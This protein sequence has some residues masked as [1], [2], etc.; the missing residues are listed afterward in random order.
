MSDAQDLLP[1]QCT[2]S[3]A[4]ARICCLPWS[5]N[6]TIRSRLIRTDSVFIVPS[7]VAGA[8]SGVVF[9]GRSRQVQDITAEATR[10]VGWNR[11]GTVDVR[12]HPSVLIGFSVSTGS[13]LRMSEIKRNKLVSAIQLFT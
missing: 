6:G 11:V 8:A 9:L 12:H 5:G 1:Q 2:N 13:M 3:F 4:T 7:L 10:V